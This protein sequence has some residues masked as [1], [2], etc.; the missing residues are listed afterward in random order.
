MSS[1]LTRSLSSRTVLSTSV[2]LK[3]VCRHARLRDPLRSFT[4]SITAPSR[5]TG[6]R[7]LSSVLRHTLSVPRTVTLV[8]P[9]LVTRTRASPRSSRTRSRTLRRTRNRTRGRRAEKVLLPLL[10]PTTTP[11]TAR[12]RLTPVRCRLCLR[13]SLMPTV[14]AGTRLCRSLACSLHP[15]ASRQSTTGTHT[16]CPPLCD[17]T[18]TE[19]IRAI[20]ATARTPPTASIRHD[21]ATGGRTSVRRT[22]AQ[23]AA[24]RSRTRTHGNL[25]QPQTK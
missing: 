15:T 3:V 21:R 17:T 9:V 11:T 16:T 2:T 25:P 5:M 24:R 14:Q 22:V 19:A 13:A 18:R 20:Q 6:G 1:R 10:R 4:R 8:P 23:S 7:R 12:L